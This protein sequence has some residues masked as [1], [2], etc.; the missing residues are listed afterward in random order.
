MPI[1]TPRGR[2]AAYRAVWQWPL[3]SPARL[4]L[5]TASVLALAAGITLGIG[6]LRGLP[7]LS[8]RPAGPAAVATGA[9]APGPA[10]GAA[11][12]AATALPP[13]AELRPPSLP[14]SKAPAA[15]LRVAGRW[16]AAWL[17]PPPGT[18]TEEWLDGLRP[19]TT[20]EYL[21]TLA[22]VAPENIPATKV[23]GQPRPVQ[24]APRSVEV[25]VRTDGPTLLLLVVETE[26]GWRVAGHDRV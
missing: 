23:T 10:T 2:A 6:A 8:D 5:T 25:E 4:A 16:S 9:P 7:S 22:G 14:L 18:T 24:V 11:A 13:V 21:P 19:Y 17:R 26:N 12:S 15:A 1:R 3:R 20:E